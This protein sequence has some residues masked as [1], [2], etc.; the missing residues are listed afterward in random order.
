MM[1]GRRLLV[2]DG[3]KVDY[4]EYRCI[5]SLCYTDKERR[6]GVPLVGWMENLVMSR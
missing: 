4:Y 5:I 1:A 6:R 3:T 2:Y